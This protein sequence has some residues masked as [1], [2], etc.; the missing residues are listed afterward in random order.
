MTDPPRIFPVLD[1]EQAVRLASFKA[2][3]PDVVVG[4]LGFGHWQGRIPAE[5]GETV[6]TRDTLPE[7]LDRLGELLGG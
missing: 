7:L 4:E 6:V 3:H 2:L 5:D 1:Y